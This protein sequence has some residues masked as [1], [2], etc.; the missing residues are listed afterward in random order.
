MALILSMY[1][2]TMP[3]RAS[4]K[5]FTAS[6]SW[7]NTSGL[8]V[9]AAQ[10]GMVGVQ[11]AV[12]ESFHGFPVEHVGKFF[13]LKEFDLLDFVG[14]AE[15]VKEVEEGHARPQWPKGGPLRQGP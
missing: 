3:G 5:G 9:S 7:K 1:F 14:G 10:L 8:W 12:A 4:T 15:P 6:R 13:L 2:R 11:G